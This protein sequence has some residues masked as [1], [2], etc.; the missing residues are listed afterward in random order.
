MR[1]AAGYQCLAALLLLFAACARALRSPVFL[2]RAG[3]KKF[4][5]VSTTALAAGPDPALLLPTL[6]GTT[7]V[8]F[9]LFNG[10]DV[11]S[12]VDLTD[13]GRARAK[14]QRRAERMARGD[15]K[16]PDPNADPYRY[17]LPFEDDDDEIDILGGP[18]KTGGCG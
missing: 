10:I 17:R 14:Q 15:Y 16:A 4:R 7:A 18:P 8:V 13:A 12:K 3:A 1:P 9:V 5:A 6:L 11:N 2:H